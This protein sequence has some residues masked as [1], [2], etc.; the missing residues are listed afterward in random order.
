MDQKT[1]APK[2]YPSRSPNLDLS[3]SRLGSGTDHCSSLIDTGVDALGQGLGPAWGTAGDS[4]QEAQCLRPEPAPELAN[5]DSR[6]FGPLLAL[7]RLLAESRVLFTFLSGWKKSREEYFVACKSLY[8]IKFSLSIKDVLLELSHLSWFTYCQWLLLH[9]NG[10]PDSLPKRSPKIY[11]I[12]PVWK[13]LSQGCHSL[14]GAG[15]FFLSSHHALSCF[16]FSTLK[17]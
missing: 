2:L 5:Y 13:M 15:G 9:W 1:V 11:T 4:S 3:G 8:E 12:Q 7:C 6:M 14:L 17:K 16:V 10:R